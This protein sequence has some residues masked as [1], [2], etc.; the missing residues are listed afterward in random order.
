[1]SNGIYLLDSNALISPH[2]RYYRFTFCPGF[3]DFVYQQFEEKETASI[4]KVY[5]EI[6]R[7]SDALSV[8]LTTQLDKKHFA[9]T[10]ID[11][12]VLSKYDEVST[13]V[14]SSEQYDENAK[15][16]FLQVDAADPWICAYAATYGLTVVTEEV[17]APHAKR[18]VSLADLLDA[19]DV[20]YV[21][22]FEYLETQQA[23]FVLNT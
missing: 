6:S 1:M 18:R 4:L 15:R 23:K 21:N 13:W 11:N 14:L 2:R 17:S 3:W 19:F 12:A 20:P 7:N 8:W 16:K 9:D 10:T 5:D 22:L